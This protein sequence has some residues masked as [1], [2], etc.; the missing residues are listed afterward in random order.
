[1][2]ASEQQPIL[3]VRPN[4]SDAQE[5]SV[6]GPERRLVLVFVCLLTVGSH[7]GKH[8]IS[9]LGPAIINR[10]EISRSQYGLIFSTQELPSA[11]LPV[12]GGI[13]ITT[14]RLPYGP[15][16]VFLASLVLMGQVL[17]SMAVQA[18]SYALLMAG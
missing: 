7:F 18:K 1:M 9:S 11:V 17:S 3:G 4:T 5:C 8:F 2:D 15:V 10:L 6:A 14:L 12:L 13:L 16:I